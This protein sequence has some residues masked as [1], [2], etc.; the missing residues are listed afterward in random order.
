M[1]NCHRKVLLH[2]H[3]QPPRLIAAA[4]VTEAAVV[5]TE[6]V[7]AITEA[8]ATEAVAVVT[9]AVAAVTEAVAAE[10][11]EVT[12][13][14]AVADVFDYRLRITYRNASIFRCKFF[15]P[16]INVLVT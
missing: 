7:A 13:E 4:E 10:A 16:K 5:V 9:E 11:T 2:K 3:L 8:A 15:L 12:A 1:K 6:A 14:E